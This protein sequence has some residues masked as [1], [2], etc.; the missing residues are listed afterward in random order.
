VGY[1]TGGGCD[2]GASIRAANI[3]SRTPGPARTG[4]VTKVFRHRLPP[5]WNEAVTSAFGAAGSAAPRRPRP[6]SSGLPSTVAP[7][8]R[9]AAAGQTPAGLDEPNGY[10]V[11]K[12]LF[13]TQQIQHPLDRP[14]RASAPLNLTFSGSITDP[15][16]Q[17]GC[18]RF[19]GMSAAVN[20]RLPLA[21]MQI[22]SIPGTLGLYPDAQTSTAWP[23]TSTSRSDPGDA[24]TSRA[25]GPT[26]MRFAA[27]FGASSPPGSTS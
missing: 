24:A 8:S 11:F 6:L 15:F 16:G 22:A 27:F 18:P 2:V 5:Q 1:P 4:D 20:P 13:G 19:D 23:A 25:E 10:T 7:G 17:P 9:F 12:G 3:V 26:K 14:S 21:S